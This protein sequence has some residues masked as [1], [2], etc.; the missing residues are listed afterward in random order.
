MCL[1]P[2]DNWA[3][4]AKIKSTDKAEERDEKGDGKF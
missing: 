2:F 3:E 1:I 4:M